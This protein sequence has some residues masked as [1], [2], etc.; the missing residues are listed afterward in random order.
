MTVIV[1]VLFAVAVIPF[2]PGAVT[3]F[4]FGIADVCSS[5]DRTAV[6][7][8]SFW[9]GLV[10]LIRTGVELDDL[11]LLLGLLP[12]QPSGID[13]PAHGNDI[14]YILAKE[15]E[16]VCQ[17]NHGEQIV[18]E[19]VKE[20]IHQ[21]DGQIK[22]CEDPCL[23]GDNEEE[24][25]LSVREKGCVAQEQAQV[26]IGN[27]CSSTEDQ[28]ENIHHQN[29]CQIEQIEPKGTPNMFHGL[30]QRIV[31]EQGNSHQQQIINPVSQRIA[32]QTP[33]LSLQN[34]IPVKVQQVIEGVVSQH[35]AHHIYHSGAKSDVQHQIGN[36][37]VFILEAIKLKLSAQVFQ[38]KS[39]PK[40]SIY[41][42]LPVKQGN[43]Y[44]RIVN[45]FCI[46][47]QKR[48]LTFLK[49]YVEYIRKLHTALSRA[50]EGT[51]R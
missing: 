4:Q 7:I 50:V 32:D 23:Y 29:A 37:F 30:S 31:T 20:K 28:T 3:E 26:Q 5:T 27:I 42:I 35:L 12:E 1:D 47:N 44:R 46:K 45:I 8:G 18:G 41:N 22:Q 11:C 9:C 21:N 34:Q 17:R 13:S 16:V 48:V 51:A 40:N 49:K 24:E 36:T 33:D 2:A 6:G 43:V 19:G 25:E 15:Q 10:C 14:Q 39:T 38:R